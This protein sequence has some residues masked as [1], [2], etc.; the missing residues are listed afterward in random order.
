MNELLYSLAIVIF[1]WS[2]VNTFLHGYYVHKYSN[3]DEAEF[4][5]DR[6]MKT[7]APVAGAFL[8]VVFSETLLAVIAA[9]GICIELI[10]L[11]T[12]NQSSLTKFKRF[13]RGED[14]E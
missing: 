9:I 11:F 1:Y 3:I 6:D 14:N 12:N 7:W 8:L 4:I 13:L 2:P 10:M 5:L